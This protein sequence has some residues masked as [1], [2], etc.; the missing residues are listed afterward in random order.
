M[1]GDNSCCCCCRSRRG[2]SVESGGPKLNDLM[3]GFV[4]N[5]ALVSPVWLHAKGKMS[6]SR[7]DEG[8][9]NSLEGFILVVPFWVISIFNESALI[10][11][12]NDLI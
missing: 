7:R 11:R 3:V 1:P 9:Q 6:G 2:E 4:Y 12:S 5:V 8:F 10:I